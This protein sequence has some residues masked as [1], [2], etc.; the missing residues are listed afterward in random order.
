MRVLAVLLF[1]LSGA[2]LAALGLI[3]LHDNEAPITA[4]LLLVVIVAGGGVGAE[5]GWIYGMVDDA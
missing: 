4:W 1:A 5:V 3:A 2:S